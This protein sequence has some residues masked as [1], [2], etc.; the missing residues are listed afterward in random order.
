[1]FDYC[2]YLVE[3]LVY[4]PIY[5]FDFVDLL[6]DPIDWELNYLNLRVV[7]SFAYDLSGYR[8]NLT[9]FMFADP[10]LGFV[11]D[12]IHL[13]RLTWWTDLWEYSPH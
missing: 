11:I 10:G 6:L 5:Q 3:D 8:Q 4:P 12:F 13:H 9:V 2:P 1:M 7:V